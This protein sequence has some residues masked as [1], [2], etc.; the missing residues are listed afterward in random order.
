MNERENLT[1]TTFIIP[2]CIESEDR[3][4]NTFITLSYLCKYL[5]TNI[6]IFEYDKEQKVDKILDKIDKGESIIIY[7][8]IKNEGNVF[9][10]TKLLNEMLTIT[11]TPVVVNYDIDIILP[12]ENYKLCERHIQ[13][14]NIDVAYPYFEGNSQICIDYNGRDVLL[15]TLDITTVDSKNTTIE[16]SYA[17]HCKFFNRQ[18]YIEGGMENEK[19][20][21]Y[22][23]EDLELKYRFV[24]LGYKV[25]HLNA[26]VFHIEHS[27]TFNSDVTNPYHTENCELYKFLGSLSILE[28]KKYY[29]EV[30]YIKK[31][32][33]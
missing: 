32:L 6:I 26:R 23:P 4:I 22:G 3:A 20:I 1:N 13:T 14:N 12:P 25:F 5:K 19:F 30:D 18:S 33:I 28:L 8:F 21:S 7:K 16:K 17:G 9:H 11:T 27:R 15:N 2:L 10:R 29:K 24:K 31:Y